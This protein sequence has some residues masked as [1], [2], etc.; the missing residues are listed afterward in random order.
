MQYLYKYTQGTPGNNYNEWVIETSCP[1]AS[2]TNTEFD[3]INSAAGTINCQKTI[4]GY[5]K[6]SSNKLFKTLSKQ[7]ITDISQTGCGKASGSEINE[8]NANYELV[9]D[10][11]GYYVSG[12]FPTKVISCLDGT[13]CG[14]GEI[15]TKCAQQSDVGK[16]Y[17]AHGEVKLC[18]SVNKGMATI[19]GADG[20]I[21]LSPNRF[22]SYITKR[23][24]HD[25]FQA[26]ER[27]VEVVEDG[28][29][30]LK[31]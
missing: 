23:N 28:E 1:S 8:S 31:K 11:K 20:R 16:L 2:I 9:A 12:E 15:G 25:P 22:V 6:S 5:C 7:V 21:R 17:W 10:N 26:K 30:S 24:I 13:T 18:V 19:F 14:E 4:D 27:D 3:T 29:E